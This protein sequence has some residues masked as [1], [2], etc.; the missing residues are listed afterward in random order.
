MTNMI[1]LD[2]AGHDDPQ[3]IALAQRIVNGAIVILQAR[4]VF[5]VHIDNWFD[6]KWLE[7]RCRRG[8][9]VLLVPPFNPNRIESQKHF[10][11]DAEESSWASVGFTRLVHVRQ[12]GRSSL[13]QPLDRFSKHAAFVW[14]SGNTAANRVGSLMVYLSGAEDYAWYA[15]FRK[16]EHWHVADEKR[17]TRLALETFEKRG[18]QEEGSAIGC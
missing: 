11:W 12:S 6:H 5:L 3:F 8:Y 15:S 18:L 1:E 13:D 17:I 9:E 7:W 2:A 4:E 14:Y 10:V 16:K